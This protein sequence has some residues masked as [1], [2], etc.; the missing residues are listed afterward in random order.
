MLNGIENT[1]VKTHGLDELGIAREAPTHWNPPAPVLYEHAVRRGEGLIAEGGPLAVDTGVHTGRSP[2]DKFLVDEPC[3]RDRI[4]WGE[5]NQPMSEAAFDRI[6]ERQRA[7]LADKEL[8][9]QDCYGGA[10]PRFRLPVRIVTQYAWHSLFVRDLLIRESDEAALRDFRPEFTIVDTPDFEADPATDGTPSGTFIL[11]N[12]ARKLVLIGGTEYAGE[13]KKSVF[14]ILNY[15]LPLRGVLGMHCSANYGEDRDDVALF[16]G[17]SGTGKTTLSTS[18]DRTLIGDDEHGWGDDGV[19]NFEG[20][21]YAKAIRVREETEPEIFATTRRFGTIL[22]N[23]VIDPK[24]RRLDLDSAALTENTR[25]GYPITHLPRADTRG[26]AGH[27]RQIFFL[28]Y[29]AFGVLPPIAKLTAEQAMFHYLAGYTSKV[30]G[31]ETGVTEPQL[32]FSPC[33]GGPF[34][35]LRPR[36]YAE[37]LGRKIDRHE[38]R[39]WLVNTGINGGPYG[40]GK[41]IAMPVTRS[42]IQAALSGELDDVPARTDDSFHISRLASCPGL[43]AEVLDPRASWSDPEAYDRKAAELAAR[44]RENHDRTRQA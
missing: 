33:F 9:V 15:L 37:L 6:W 26:V 25:A 7:Y 1:V 17:L 8:F 40:I 29:D 27:P 11:I 19:F 24:T 18:P 32:V 12:L 2:H 4:W 22:E 42:L 23:V 10:D 28:T 30:A 43:A 21:C 20:G 31:T 3:S 13:I 34:L 35:P 44:F 39:C 16:F 41:R 38:V 5:Y 36:E 14:S